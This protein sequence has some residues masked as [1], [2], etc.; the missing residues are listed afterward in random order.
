[1]QSTTDDG[2]DKRPNDTLSLSRITDLRGE[3]HATVRHHA[4]TIISIGAALE[5]LDVALQRAVATGLADDQQALVAA[6]RL[7][8]T[9]L[10]GEAAR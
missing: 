2:S 8:A 10:D 6:G 7:L 9:L 3:A 4:A 5:A 1:M